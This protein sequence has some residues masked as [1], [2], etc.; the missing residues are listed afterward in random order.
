[1]ALNRWVTQRT[2]ASTAASASA[3]VADGVAGRH[4]H[5]PR[6]QRTRSGRAP[7]GSS[8]AR[9]TRRDA[10]S[11]GDQ[12]VARSSA[13]GAPSAVGGARSQR[14]R[15]APRRSG[16]R[17]GPSR[18]RPSGVASGTRGQRRAAARPPGRPG[19][20]RGRRGGPV[21]IVGSQ[22]VT[23]VAGQQRPPGPTGARARRSRSMP[24]PP[25]HCRSTSP[26]TTRRP[27]RP[28]RR[29]AHRRS[30]TEGRAPAGRRRRARAP[31][32]AGGRQGVWPGGRYGVTFDGRRLGSPRGPGTA[33]V[34]FG[35]NVRTV[36]CL[37]THANDGR[38][39]HETAC[40]PDEPGRN[41]PSPAA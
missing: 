13:A 6:R 16:A 32:T 15:W 17:N 18:W 27:G 30:P 29:P 26:G 20:G 33:R 28:A 36:E 7:P 40:V 41:P 23:P 22:A 31:G 25:L 12:P 38:A 35:T 19:P 3:A 8:G 2:P 4:H 21:T 10:G 9:V 34:A 39:G 24:N 1:M 11:A 5:A 14:R 37:P